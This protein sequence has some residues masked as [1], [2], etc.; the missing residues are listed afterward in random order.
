MKGAVLVLTFT[1]GLTAIAAQ[2]PRDNPPPSI[3]H[4]R[5]ERELRATVQA[6]G[7]T[8]ETYLELARVETELHRFPEAVAALHGT[9]E[10][11]PSVA[12]V[13]HQVATICWQYANQ[14]VT[15]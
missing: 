14:T 5:R 13:Q 3:E 12:E 1:T 10:L 6:G 4:A 15:E 8:R 2:T 7:A 11:Q 9:A